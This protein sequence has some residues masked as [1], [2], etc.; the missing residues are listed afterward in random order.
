MTFFFFFYDFSIGGPRKI[1]LYKE[2][3]IGAFLGNEIFYVPTTWLRSTFIGCGG[4]EERTLRLSYR[5]LSSS[6]GGGEGDRISGLGRFRDEGLW[7]RGKYSRENVAAELCYNII[8]SLHLRDS[9]VFIPV[10][11]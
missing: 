6:T 2:P 5:K 8:S 9:T 11:R 4:G 7:N 3:E 1:Y 10:M